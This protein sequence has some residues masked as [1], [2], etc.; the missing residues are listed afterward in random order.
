MRTSSY[1]LRLDA[2]H[3][4]S[5]DQLVVIDSCF[6]GLV[7]VRGMDTALESHLQ[8]RCRETLTASDAK[9]PVVEENGN[10]VFTKAFVD[11]LNGGAFGD[12]QE[13]VTTINL[14]SY[15]AKRLSAHQQIPHYG[16]FSQSHDAF[17]RFVF[18]HPNSL[19]QIN[20]T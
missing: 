15:V 20:S 10:G 14:H 2:R 8:Q 9:T 17:G 6:S 4:Y 19:D 7:A 1:E 3:S 18:A 16:H 11:G 5:T 13:Y 12:G